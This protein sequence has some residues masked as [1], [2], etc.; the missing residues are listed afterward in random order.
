MSGAIGRGVAAMM[1]VGALGAFAPA[2]AQ[3]PAAE[4]YKNLKE[5][6]V[7]I[8]SAPGG[9]YDQYGRLLA[10][11]IGPHLGSAT[12]VIPRNMP[13][14]SGRA[15][16]NYIFNVAPKDGSAVGTTLR[17]IPFDPLMG[18]TETK[19]D[20]E[21]LTWIGSLNAETSLCVSWHTTPFRTIEDTKKKEILMGSSGPSAADSTHVKLLNRVV[22]T[23]MKIVPGYLGSSEVHLAM[24][25]GEVEGRCGLGWDSIVSRYKNWLDEKKINL[26]VQL[27]VDKH[28]DIPD[29]PW[30]MDFAKTEADRQLV[31]LS[32]GP[33]KMGRPVFAPPDMASDRVAFLRTAFV[34]TM[35]DPELIADAKK[36]EIDI[37]YMDGAATDA[38][39]RQLYATPKAVVE[40]ARAIMEGK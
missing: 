35:K 29:V 24:E 34:A 1:T 17:N 16:L 21:R 8:G 22:G 32:L 27:A 7:Y 18:I 37:V 10:R 40:D 12:T 28:P 31:A 2:G 38:L 33:N 5:F 15:V 19:I 11:H 30:I 13:A 14:G 9:G 39:Y 20:P 25:R 36:M 3:V 26:L 6:N 23:K 4:F